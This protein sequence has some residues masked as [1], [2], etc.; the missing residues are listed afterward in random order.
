MV[1]TTLLLTVPFLTVIAYTNM[2]IDPGR[3]Y[4]IDRDDMIEYDIVRMMREGHN[5]E[6]IGNYNERLVRRDFINQ[7]E[8]PVDVIIAGS[9]RGALI[10][11]E[12][13]N[14]DSMFNTSVAGGSLDDVIGFYGVLHQYDLLPKTY[15]IV[16]DPWMLNDNHY[17][18][19]YER[20]LG[21]GYYHYMTTRMGYSVDERLKE[22]DSFYEPGSTDPISFWDLSEDVK[23]NLISITYFQASIQR[24]FNT[25]IIVRPDTWPVATDSEDGESAFLRPDG[26][27]CYPLAYR[28]ADAEKATVRASMSFP[29]SIIGLED[30]TEMESV[31]KQIF[32][33]FLKCVQQ[34]GVEIKIVI[35]PISNTLVEYMKVFERYEN[36]F[37]AEEMIYDIAAS[38]GIEITG[39]FDPEKL[40]YDM[41]CFY[42]GYHLREQYIA[43]IVRPFRQ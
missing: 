31:R 33:D 16:F 22:I 26:S 23:W 2:Y 21:D 36:F 42:D 7:M 3:L 34:D 18:G 39:S 17:D 14:A 28:S 1:L 29:E 9:S 15:I 13:L 11:T 12:M 37:K 41:N 5:V 10:T 4:H 30:Y 35:E 6:N 24:Y 25:E 19:R 20:S 32:I 8:A 38:F 27:F 40:N 43:E